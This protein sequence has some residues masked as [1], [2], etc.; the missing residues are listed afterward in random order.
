[1]KGRT[2]R[3]FT[4][5]DIFSYSQALLF[6]YLLSFTLWHGPRQ[7]FKHPH[8][9]IDSA[10]HSRTLTPENTNPD[11]QIHLIILIL[12][13]FF[14]L[15]FPI[16]EIFWNR[17]DFAVAKLSIYHRNCESWEVSY[18]SSFFRKLI[19]FYSCIAWINFQWNYQSRILSF[20][21][22]TFNWIRCILHKTGESGWT[23]WDKFI[24]VAPQN[25]VPRLS[26]LSWG[27]HHNN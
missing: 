20:R 12:T 18:F 24:T 14:E 10:R 1:M 19:W 6:P 9:Q 17:Q 13:I 7:A 27:V 5:W 25:A 4:L 22:I 8:T 15:I 21:L 2:S 16:F 23:A 11:R 3:L 26:S